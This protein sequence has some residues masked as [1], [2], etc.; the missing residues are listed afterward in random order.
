MSCPFPVG[1]PLRKN[2][3][4]AVGINRQQSA[5]PAPC[6]SRASCFMFPPEPIAAWAVVKNSLKSAPIKHG[7]FSFYS[8]IEKKA[9]L[10]QSF[11]LM[12]F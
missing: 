7:K 3:P 9:A 10:I 8:G 12:K 5:F 6:L 4:I 1:L 11:I 2:A